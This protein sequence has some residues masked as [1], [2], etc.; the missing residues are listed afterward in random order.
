MYPKSYYPCPPEYSEKYHEI[1]EYFRPQIDEILNS[2]P[3]TYKTWRNHHLLIEGEDTFEQFAEI[4]KKNVIITHREKISFLEYVTERLMWYSL[5]HDYKTARIS[6]K[7]DI[8]Y[9]KVR[10][11]SQMGPKLDALFSRGPDGTKDRNLKTLR[12]EP[13]DDSLFTK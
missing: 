11:S 9:G 10:W 2:K 8:G 4:L 3:S 6:L 1:S 13:F 12:T 7:D 5:A